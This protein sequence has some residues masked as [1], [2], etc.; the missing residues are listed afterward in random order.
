M[1]AAQASY[2]YGMAA[3]LGTNT[4]VDA[5]CSYIIGVTFL[6]ERHV[7]GAA[8]TVVI[9]VAG[10]AAA[11]GLFLLARGSRPTN[12]ISPAQATGQFST[13]VVPQKIR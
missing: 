11:A 12:R 9:A 2:R 10:S 7:A 5:A 1:F 8:G 6:G 3:Q 13:P 4:F